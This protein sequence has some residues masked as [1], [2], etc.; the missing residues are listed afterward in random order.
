[1]KN[2]LNLTV[3][4]RLITVFLALLI[5]PTSVVGSISYLVTKNELTDEQHHSAEQSLQLIDS[6]ISTFI[7]PK[8]NQISMLAEYIDEAKLTTDKEALNV[9]F[10]EYLALH[11]EVDI[12]YVGKADKEMIRRP[13]YEYA[14]DYDPTARPWYTTAM[15]AKGETIITE[16]YISS[17]SGELVITVAKTL[18]NGQGVVALDMSIEQLATITN[19]TKIGQKG[20]F[21]LLNRE[22]QFI[23]HPTNESGEEAE[24][25]FIEAYSAAKEDTQFAYV[26][27]QNDVTGWH[28]VGAIHKEETK[29]ASQIIL[30]INIATVL[31]FLLI[32]GIIC[33]FVIISILRPLRILT[34]KAEQISQGD[35]TVHLS[36]DTTNDEIGRLNGMFVQMRNNLRQLI[37]TVKDKTVEL[38][39]SAEVLREGSEQT[40]AATEQTT[41]AIQS[42]A[43]GA[44]EQLQANMSNLNTLSE[45]STIVNEMAAQNRQVK[46]LTDHAMDEANSGIA[47][48]QSTVQQIQSVQ[49]SVQLSNDKMTVLTQN[50]D[51][52]RSIIGIITDIADQTNLLALNASIEAAR[53][54]EHGKGFA[55]VAQE[56]GKLAATSRESTEQIRNLIQMIIA[57]TEASSVMM[58]TANEDVH[59]G[60][61]LTNETAN[62]FATITAQLQNIEP[63]VESLS[64]SAQKM[65]AA[66][67]ESTGA[68]STLMEFAEQTAASSEEVAASTEQI[69]ASMQEIGAASETLQQMVDDL[70]TQV[71]RFNV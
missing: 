2:L 18:Q 33:Y 16:P 12:I 35:L 43:T 14:A 55:V 71:N 22:Q 41:L 58:Q 1:M 3:K 5:V 59:R 66:M 27:K 24:P 29:D 20:F 38:Q 17:S 53:A 51:Q 42:V 48:V 45:A 26:T 4:Q 28:L 60:L 32:G 37:G 9:M 69:N 31:I 21:T 7:Q 6:S 39:N 36:E 23:A 54:G 61:Q 46:K 8:L 19:A 50:V 47:V 57:D 62:K 13:Y 15:D 34:T 11:E 67:D 63:V 70:S 10:D 44:D 40:I 56:V 30:I 68:A 49:T 52:I 65:T 25:S 64:A